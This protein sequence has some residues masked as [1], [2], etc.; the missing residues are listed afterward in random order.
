[1]ISAKPNPMK[2]FRSRARLSRRCAD[3]SNTIWPRTARLFLTGRALADRTPLFLV[4]F[5]R[6]LDEAGD[7]IAV[8]EAGV[9][10]E[11][12]VHAHGREARYRVHLVE[13]CL[14]VSG[15]EEVHPR[16]AGAID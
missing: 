8:G 10:P 6:Q 1:M 3:S 9:F 13:V 15:E 7:E 5:E 16:Q 12:R 14:A 4:A 11:L 2:S